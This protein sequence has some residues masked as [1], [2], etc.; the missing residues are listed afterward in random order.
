MII[1]RDIFITNVRYREDEANE[2]LQGFI[3]MGQ[4]SRPRVPRGIEPAYVGKFIRQNVKIDNGP[5]VYNK[6]LACI[7][8]YERPDAALHLALTL[9]GQE[10][11]IREIKR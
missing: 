1:R 10:K 9:I 5:D 4:M 11:T 3:F 2:L 6:S 7:R 8:Y